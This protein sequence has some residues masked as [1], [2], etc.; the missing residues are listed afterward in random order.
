[1][2]AKYTPTQ[3]RRRNFKNLRSKLIFITLDLANPRDTEKD[4]QNNNHIL[5]SFDVIWTP[6]KCLQNPYKPNESTFGLSSVRLLGY[7]VPRANGTMPLAENCLL[8]TM[9]NQLRQVF[10]TINFYRRS[11]SKAAVSQDPLKNLVQGRIVHK[12]GRA[13]GQKC[14]LQVMRNLKVTASRSREMLWRKAFEFRSINIVDF[15][16]GVQ[17]QV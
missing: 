5:P 17:V 11:I 3:I 7:T 12:K 1:M 15:I 2:T 6:L 10:D 4:P 16:L 14:E 9:A 8:P 13:V